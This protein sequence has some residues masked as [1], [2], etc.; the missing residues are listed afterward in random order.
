VRQTGRLWIGVRA[1]RKIERHVHI[2][3]QAGRLPDWETSRQAAGKD[4]GQTGK[5]KD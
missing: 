4:D 1:D 5:L 3:R 2:R